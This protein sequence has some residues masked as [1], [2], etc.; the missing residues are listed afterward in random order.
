MHEFDWPQSLQGYILS[1]F[2]VGYVL[3][4]LPY[5]LLA[6]QIGGQ[7]VILFAIFLTAA[8]T[9]STPFTILYGG[10]Y[11]LIFLRFMLGC[12][13]AGLYPS[14]ATLLAAW[15]PKNERGRIG[16]IVYCAAPVCFQRFE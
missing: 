16:S 4:H 1:S 8:I 11:A 5:G 10:P 13:Q 7:P 9:L 6:E 3:M 14:I 12:V 2:Y 15:V